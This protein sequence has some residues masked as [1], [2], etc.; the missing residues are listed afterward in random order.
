MDSLICPISR[1]DLGIVVRCVTTKWEAAGETS[2]AVL[3]HFADL[4]ASIPASEEQQGHENTSTKECKP[5]LT[6]QG[7]SQLFHENIHHTSEDSSLRLY[8]ADKE[9]G[10]RRR[11]LTP[12]SRTSRTT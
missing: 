12:R 6:Y 1:G 4:P 9:I 8:Y 3:P 11:P 5:D 7:R 2:V 10:L